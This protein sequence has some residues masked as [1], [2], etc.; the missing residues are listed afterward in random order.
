MC[1]NIAINL[2]LY[3]NI[4][5]ALKIVVDRTMSIDFFSQKFPRRSNK[6][7]EVKYIQR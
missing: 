4:L 3:F 1:Q 7:R 5:E 6:F 2:N